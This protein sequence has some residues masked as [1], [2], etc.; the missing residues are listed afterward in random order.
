MCHPHQLPLNPRGY[1]FSRKHHKN[2]HLAL[3]HTILWAA[4]RKIEKNRI[5]FSVPSSFSMI[6]SKQRL[7]ISNAEWNMKNAFTSMFWIK[8]HKHCDTQIHY[9]KHFPT[10]SINLPYSDS[11]VHGASMGPIWVLSAQ[12]GPH[13]GPMN[14]PIRV[15]ILVANLLVSPSRSRSFRSRKEAQQ[16][17]KS[18]GCRKSTSP[19]MACTRLTSVSSR[20]DPEGGSLILSRSA[21]QK[22]FQ[23]LALINT[24]SYWESPGQKG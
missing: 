15:M 11:Q 18:F 12:G 22:E 8:L 20:S 1:C 21:N 4:F 5:W 2:N 19:V 13:V 9:S 14:L 10:N 23:R 24:L 17:S 7:T 3:I 6:I 16:S